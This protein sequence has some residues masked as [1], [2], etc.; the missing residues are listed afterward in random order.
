MIIAMLRS[1]ICNIKGSA[2]RSPIHVKIMVEP[3]TII[4][5]KLKHVVSYYC[6]SGMASADGAKLGEN[7]LNITFC[8]MLQV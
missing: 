3:E 1:L 5:V 7:V 4:R 8:S 2:I 6:G